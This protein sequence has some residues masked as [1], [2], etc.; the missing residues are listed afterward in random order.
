MK[1]LLIIGGTGFLG[2]AIVGELA[3]RAAGADSCFTLPTRRRDR[4]RHLLVLPTATVV[5][6]D[7]HDPAT[8][9]RLMAGQDADQPG[10]NIERR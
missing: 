3:H 5:E 1:N 9:A 2:T 6:A 4:A 7:V 8:L 10:G